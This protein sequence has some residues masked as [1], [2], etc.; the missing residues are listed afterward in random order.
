MREREQAYLL[1][2]CHPSKVNMID[3]EPTTFLKHTANF[4]FLDKL[5]GDLVRNLIRNI[6]F[7]LS[8]KKNRGNEDQMT[9]E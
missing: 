6:R 8:S 7:H 4:I 3:D 2:E 5:S 9:A 1:L